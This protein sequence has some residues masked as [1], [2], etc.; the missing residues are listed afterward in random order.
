MTFN[1]NNDKK[2]SSIT[3][4]LQNIEDLSTGEIKTIKNDWSN[5]NQE[6]NWSFTTDRKTFTGR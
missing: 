2:Q 4:G 1:I 5:K 3:F 6:P